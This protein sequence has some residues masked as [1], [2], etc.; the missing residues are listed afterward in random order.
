[1]GI[2][3]M[4]FNT[5]AITIII[6]VSII[7]DKNVPKGIKITKANIEKV[8]ITWKY[9]TF[10]LEIPIIREIILITIMPDTICIIP[11]KIKNVTISVNGTIINK[12]P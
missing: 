5:P 10:F 11:N 4:S 7:W 1:M 9:T 6:S 12:I 2:I 3:Q 8:A